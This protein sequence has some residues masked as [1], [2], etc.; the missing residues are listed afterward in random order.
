MPMA[1]T[2]S[3]PLIDSSDSASYAT[4][5]PKLSALIPPGHRPPEPSANEDYV[6]DMEGI[7]GTSATALTSSSC[8]CDDGH[9]I[10]WCD[11]CIRNNLSHLPEEGHIDLW[12][13]CMESEGSLAVLESMIALQMRLLSVLVPLVL[14]FILRVYMMGYIDDRYASRE[15]QHSIFFKGPE[16]FRR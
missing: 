4:V 12:R 15:P 3:T 13:R 1:S 14:L 8:D 7:T 11:Y 10:L 5:R 16:C 6:V 9:D 2:Q